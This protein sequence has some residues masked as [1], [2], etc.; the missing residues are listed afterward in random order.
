MQS[1]LMS[2]LIACISGVAECDIR[3]QGA[4]QHVSVCNVLPAEKRKT[5]GA[6]PIYAR[7]VMD[8]TDYFVAISPSC[9]E[10]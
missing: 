3:D 5:T 9:K 7:F 10:S 6:R 1:I 2:A 4:Y 8:G